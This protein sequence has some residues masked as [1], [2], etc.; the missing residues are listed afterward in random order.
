MLLQRHFFYLQT[1]NRL[2]FLSKITMAKYD[3]K[4][5]AIMRLQICT[6]CIIL[7]EIVTYTYR[8]RAQEI[9][10]YAVVAI[11]E[12]VAKINEVH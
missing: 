2:K 10:A 9:E 8:G 11:L 1:Q 6:T 4:G 7:L 12:V 5:D 3:K